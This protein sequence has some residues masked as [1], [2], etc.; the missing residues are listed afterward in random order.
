MYKKI[1]WQNQFLAIILFFVSLFGLYS[2]ASAVSTP[3]P[4]DCYN[5]S[6]GNYT[7]TSC[8]TENQ[9]R[10]TVAP[11]NKCFLIS[12]SNGSQGYPVNKEINCQT[13]QIA[14]TSVNNDNLAPGCYNLTAGNYVSTSCTT[15]NQARSIVEPFNKCFVIGQSG[16]GTPSSSVNEEINCQ[17]GETAGGGPSDGCPECGGPGSA[18]GTGSGQDEEPIVTDFEG[19]SLNGPV[20]EDG[21]QYCGSKDGSGWTKISFPIGC[22]GADY[23]GPGDLNPIVDMMFALLRFI[24]AGVGLV[25]IG[26]IIWAGIHYSTS[27][28]NPQQAE[29]AI[30]RVANSITAL[31]LYIFAFALLNYVVPGGMFI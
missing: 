17:T 27:R 20:S 14:T 21:G 4:P 3:L 18:G 31:L 9:A 16:N 30:K 22:I 26:S 7:S 28:G 6:L 12:G 15:E 23:D 5:V 10:S 25:V 11:Y 2:F 13:G 8:T 1:V 29:A 19:F 24:S